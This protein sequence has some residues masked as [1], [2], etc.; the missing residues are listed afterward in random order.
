MCFG[1]FRPQ[2]KVRFRLDT[3][4]V[5]RQTTLYG[6]LEIFLCR[7]DRGFFRPT[8]GDPLRLTKGHFKLKGAIC[9]PES[10]LCLPEKPFIHPRGPFVGLKGPFF[11]MKGSFR[12]MTSLCWHGSSLC[13]PDTAFWSKR[14]PFGTRWHFVGTCRFELALASLSWP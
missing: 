14:S 3:A 9:R 2:R 7:P 1:V 8:K 4:S 12:P 10:S 13:Y 11:G 6:R 5:G